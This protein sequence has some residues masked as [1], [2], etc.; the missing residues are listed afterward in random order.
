M[1]LT[2][3][4]RAMRAFVSQRIGEGAIP[5]RELA[6]ITGWIATGQQGSGQQSS[7]S[8]RAQ[9][10]APRRERT[11]CDN[12]LPDPHPDGSSLDEDCDGACRP[13]QQI[14]STG[15]LRRAIGQR[16]RPARSPARSPPLST[17]SEP[18]RPNSYASLN[19]DSANSSASKSGGIDLH[20]PKHHGHSAPS[21][22]GKVKRDFLALYIS[23]DGLA[24]ILQ[25]R[26][27]AGRACTST[28]EVQKYVTQWPNQGALRAGCFSRNPPGKFGAVSG[29][30]AFGT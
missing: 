8:S 14:W 20:Q 6:R 18:H 1:L 25:N 9:G 3:K 15:P 4:V 10:S 16:R 12:S 27:C 23:S 19:T 28:S 11:H 5:E 22:R 26:R 30:P 13:V 21:H 17:S 2:G 24:G 29:P 7:G